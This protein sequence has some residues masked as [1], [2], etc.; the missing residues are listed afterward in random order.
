[1]AYE[2]AIGERIYSS[3]SLRGWL[4]CAGFGIEVDFVPVRLDHPGFAADIEPFAPARTVPALR[5]PGGGVVWDTAAIAETLAER[6]PEAGHWPREPG[7][8][9][10]ARAMVAEM[11]AGFGAL[12][13]A[14]PM[15]LRCRFEGYEP[16]AAVRRDLARIEALWAAAPGEGWL[17]G[18][19]SAADAFFA[20]V[21]A[22]VAGY[23]LPVGERAAAYVAAHLAEPRFR[24]WRAEGLRDPRRLEK[25]ECGLPEA[26]WPA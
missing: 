2:L 13:T 26:D 15:N 16:D 4:L 25:D 8:R 3:W 17:F 24:E 22:R 19:Y 9:A 20:P 6:H 12:R 5:L 14:C 11:H 1:M 23:G 7:E 18:A 10:L 21:A